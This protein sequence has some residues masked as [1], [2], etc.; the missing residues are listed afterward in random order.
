MQQDLKRRSEQV[1]QAPNERVQRR[2]AETRPQNHPRAERSQTRSAHFETFIQRFAITPEAHIAMSLLAS[3]ARPQSNPQVTRAQHQQARALPATQR[4]RLQRLLQSPYV[5]GSLS[6]GREPLS[7]VRP[8]SGQTAADLTGLPLQR[9][10]GPTPDLATRL[11]RYQA[12][13]AQGHLAERSSASSRNS[14]LEQAGTVLGGQPS[15]DGDNRLGAAPNL[16]SSLQRSPGHTAAIGEHLATAQTVRL[17]RQRAIQTRASEVK[18]QLIASRLQ[19]LR[20]P[21]APS[22]DSSG[23]GFTLTGLADRINTELPVLRAKHNHDPAYLAGD[24]QPVTGFVRHVGLSLGRQYQVQR[25]RDGARPMELASAVSRVH[26][27]RDR[28]DLLSATLTT[29]RPNDRETGSLQRLVAEQET[30][31]Q[32]QAEQLEASLEPV[33]QRLAEGEAEHPENLSAMIARAGGGEALPERVKRQLQPQFNFSLDLVRIHRDGS[34]DGLAKTVNAI[35]FTTGTSIFFRGGKFDPESSV[36]RGLLVHELTHVGQQLEGRAKPGVDADQSLEGEAERAGVEAEGKG[37]QGSSVIPDES[38]MAS[39]PA[40]GESRKNN[41]ILQRKV[42][43]KLKTV[44]Q[45][46]Q[47]PDE[48]VIP[49]N[50]DSTP[51]EVLIKVMILLGIDGDLAREFTKPKGRDNA[52][53]SYGGVS[54]DFKEPFFITENNIKNQKVTV[55]VDKKER[56]D[57]KTKS[58]IVN[59]KFRSEKKKL[60]S[61]SYEILTRGDEIPSQENS[62]SDQKFGR[63]DLIPYLWAQIMEAYFPDYAGIYERIKGFDKN[64]FD[65]LDKNF[66]E[67][68]YEY[69][70]GVVDIKENM[71]KKIVFREELLKSSK[72]SWTLNLTN[73]N[74][75]EVFKV[76]LEGGK[77]ESSEKE[78]ENQMLASVLS[79]MVQIGNIWVV[80]SSEGFIEETLLSLS[81]PAKTFLL[82]CRVPNEFSF[83]LEGY[84]SIASNFSRVMQELAR[85]TYDFQFITDILSNLTSRF[86]ARKILNLLDSPTDAREISKYLMKEGATVSEIERNCKDIIESSQGRFSSSRY[87]WKGD[88]T[89][90]TAF[91]RRFGEDTDSYKFLANLIEANISSRD[92]EYINNTAE[93]AKQKLLN[94]EVESN[95]VSSYFIGVDKFKLAEMIASNLNINDFENAVHSKAGAG[96]SLDDSL[97]TFLYEKSF[98]IDCYNALKVW[99]QRYPTDLTV[100]D[101]IIARLAMNGGIFDKEKLNPVM[102]R[103]KNLNPEKKKAFNDLYFLN[104]QSDFR[105]SVQIE[106]EP[107]LGGNSVDKMRARNN[108]DPNPA[109]VDEKINRINEEIKFINEGLD[110]S[111]PRTILMDL[112]DISQ[113]ARNFEKYFKILL[114]KRDSLNEVDFK[115][116]IDKMFTDWQSVTSVYGIV[117]KNQK[118]AAKSFLST[119]AT[120]ADIVF[121]GGIARTLLIESIKVALGFYIDSAGGMNRAEATEQFKN[122]II[123]TIVQPI[124]SIK[125]SEI[126]DFAF[127]SRETRASVINAM[128]KANQLIKAVGKNSTALTFVKGALGQIPSTSLTIIEN[129]DFSKPMSDSDFNALV[130]KILTSKT[131]ISGSSDSLAK[132]VLDFSMEITTALIENKL[133][134][135]KVA[136]SLLKFVTKRL[137][138][139][140]ISEKKLP[141]LAVKKTEEVRNNLRVFLESK[142]SEPPRPEEISSVILD[143]LE[144]K[145]VRKTLSETPKPKASTT[146]PR[147][148]SKPKVPTVPTKIDPPVSSSKPL[149]EPPSNQ[150]ASKPPKVEKKPKSVAPKPKDSPAPKSGKSTSTR[151]KKPVPGKSTKPAKQS[152]PA[153]EPDLPVPSKKEVSPTPAKKKKP[154]T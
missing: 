74:W 64:D 15:A 63:D 29:F 108:L 17:Q 90:S 52:E 5:A 61:D 86:C 134:S 47:N 68:N 141:G 100:P 75:Y 146:K 34:A 93:R 56:E 105:V 44:E 35:A 136:D 67:E 151:V 41:S 130:L 48:F 88:W 122:A 106:A 23:K 133:D 118:D 120:V 150:S 128:R 22:L 126:K 119:V 116:K 148:L 110:P 104:F 97:N 98:P 8:A 71:Q 1:S 131:K 57:F 92:E 43:G 115:E 114:S 4:V 80:F 109:G 42:Q 25:A 139:R 78:T 37:L 117:L 62:Q 72:K 10:A 149:S 89:L 96:T 45:K 121:T 140:G 129:M 18:T 28:S 84:G 9:V 26:D 40:G 16:R 20:T 58:T 81:G 12:E 53:F 66:H 107:F 2:E 69:L 31:L 60:E 6:L 49:I 145:P 87:I 138:S 32:R 79:A 143:T 46:P 144:D 33:A 77:N 70:E 59:E 11:Q 142:K 27:A 51:E 113:R 65:Y 137:K 112:K 153:R 91:K 36:G 73:N 50:K 85:S 13:Q 125:I 94:F 30:S 54:Y 55:L 101:W 83:H 24:T 82:N 154:N 111:N 103:Y 3:S 39:T 7:P 152:I 99:K 124:L 135:G 19:R 132:Q 14:G 102:E 38:N 123:S 21:D 95:T 76:L 127:L 147:T